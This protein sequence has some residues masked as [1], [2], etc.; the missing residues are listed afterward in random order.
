MVKV[1][2]PSWNMK[3]RTMEGDTTSEALH[4][5]LLADYKELLDIFK[6]QTDEFRDCLRVLALDGFYKQILQR[7]HVWGSILISLEKGMGVVDIFSAEVFRTLS[8][9]DS[10]T[11]SESRE[12]VGGIDEER[13]VL[14]NYLKNLL[15]NIHGLIQRNAVALKAHEASGMVEVVAAAIEAQKPKKQDFQMESDFQGVL[16]KEKFMINKISKE[17]IINKISKEQF[18]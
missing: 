13:E 4:L 11:L 2:N 17:N 10:E 8:Q 5:G 9:D 1:D 18:I 15:R 3:N 12:I 6:D 7:I 14:D 16:N